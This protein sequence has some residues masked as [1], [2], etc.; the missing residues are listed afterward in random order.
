MKVSVA[1]MAHPSRRA[2]ADALAERLDAP[3]V[4]DRRSNEWDTGRR[5]LLEYDPT[6]EYHAVVQDDAIVPDRFREALDLVTDHAEGHPLGLYVGRVRPYAR[7]VKLAVA[8][9]ERAGSPW[10]E[11]GGPW[12]GV[13]VAFPVAVIPALVAWCDLSTHPY[14]D[15]RLRAFVKQSGLWC[16]YPIPSLVDHDPGLPSLVDYGGGNRCAHRYIGDADPASIDWT[17]E[18]V[19]VNQRGRLVVPTTA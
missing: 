4:W 11:A 10:L 9:A 8:A 14:Y 18:P 1:V 2:M 16:R 5:A 15:N 7:L 6:A 3:I 12:W 19:R 17:R 13:G